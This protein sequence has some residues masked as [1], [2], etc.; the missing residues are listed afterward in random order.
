M[1]FLVRKVAVLGAGVMGAQIA[2]HCINARVPVILFDLPGKEG[3]PRNALVD[4]A[5]EQ[6]KKAPNDFAKL[7]KENSQDPG[8]AERGGDLDFFGKGM[9][10]K[11]FEDA[12]YA[13]KE[14]EISNV[15][16]SDFG[17]HIIR[18]TAIKPATYVLEPGVYKDRLPPLHIVQMRV[19]M[20]DYDPYLK[21]KRDFVAELKGQEIAALTAAAAINKLQQI[22]SGFVYDADG[23]AHWV[24]PHK[25]DLLDEILTENQNDNT[26]VV[27]N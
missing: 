9:M 17:F 20:P 5:L 12:A 15:V 25:F 4:R 6:L 3:Q 16:Q 11:P 27:Y 2:A 19:D 22:A 1:T 26:I 8:S 7:A 14:G 18:V 21:M 23:Q 24:G 10:V 13:L